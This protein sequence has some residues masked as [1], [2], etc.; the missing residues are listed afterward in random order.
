M[1]EIVKIFKYVIENGIFVYSILIFSAYFIMSVI[2][3]FEIYRYM[4]KNSFIDYSTIISSPLSPSISI[5]APAYNEGK[6]IIENIRSLLSIHYNNF[7]VIIINDGSKDDSM[8]KIITHYELEKINVPY[9]SFIETKPVRGIYKSKNKAYNK[10]VVIDKEN[11]GKSDSLN[12]GINLCDKKYFAA[13]DVDCILE[14]DALLKMIKPFLEEPE[15]RVI[16]AGGVIRIANSCKIEGGKIIEVNLSKKFLPRIQ[17]IEYSRAFLMGRMAWSRLN[18]LLLISGAFGVF[19]REIALKSGGYDCKTVGEDMELIVRMRRYMIE[20]KLKYKVVYIPDPLCWTEVPETLKVLSR[21][22]NRWTRGTIE[23]LFKHKKLF[24]NKKYGNLGMLGHPYWLFF[25]WLAPIIEFLGIFY[26]ILIAVMG[27]PNWPFFI[28][29]LLFVYLFAVSFSV[30]ALLFEELTFRKYRRK[31]D[32]VRL[33]LTSFL[34]PVLYHP[35][36]VWFALRGNFHYFIGK[37]LWG[38]MDR[39]GFTVNKET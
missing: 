15:C 17:V 34:E 32:V 36:N 6:T 21:Q 1:Y 13:V 18:G 23:T 3:A 4:K 27:H 29:L 24:F 38:K 26:F 11:G 30:W 8:E 37:N 10:L 25:E 12:A 22:R 35:L 9:N 39:T 31:R 16:A 28:V 19:D 5:I 20:H 7:E 33:I 14:E 2:S